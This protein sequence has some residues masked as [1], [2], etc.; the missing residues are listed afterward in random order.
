MSKENGASRR[1]K[2]TRGRD[3]PRELAIRRVLHAQ[4][5]RYRT[6]FPVP[7]MP[8]R[9]VDIAFTR[10]RIAIF[11]DGCF[12]HGCPLHAT[13][14][15][16][17]ADYWLPKLARN[18]ERDRETDRALVEA[19]WTVLRFWEHDAT[20]SVIATIVSVVSGRGG[21]RS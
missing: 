5:L 18:V 4:G 11:L 1:M 15:A 19:G 3:N 8:R 6:H 12:W 14:P 9:S 16:T 20:D 7:G 13:H 17:N 10:G 2:A 21:R